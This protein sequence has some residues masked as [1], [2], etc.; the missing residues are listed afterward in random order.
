MQF[1]FV[2]FPLSPRKQVTEYILLG[3][4]NSESSFVWCLLQRE[5]KKQHIFHSSS[6]K[7]KTEAENRTR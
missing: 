1:H 7:T 5:K 3:R 6:E 4:K 2:I